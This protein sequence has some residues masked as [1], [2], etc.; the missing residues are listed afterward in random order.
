MTSVVLRGMLISFALVSSI[1]MQN[2]FVVNSAMSNRLRRALLI[3]VFVWLADTTLTSVAFLGMGALVSR[4]L[5]LKI[6]IMLI[7]GLI[8]VWMGFGILRSASQIEL[9]NNNSQMPLKEAFGGAWIVA[10]ANP[11]A[12]IDTSVT[13]GALRGTLTANQ[14]LPFLGGIVLA[15]AIWFFTITMIVGIL[16]N[17]LP[18]RVLIWVNIISGFVV[19][20]YGIL[21]LINGVCLIF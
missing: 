11:Q 9:G 1:G 19:M 8:V 14:V 20:G 3:G 2:L 18:K 12:I 5:W 16:K 10:F 4:Y 15:T 6:A 17:R 13:M 7:G 21:L